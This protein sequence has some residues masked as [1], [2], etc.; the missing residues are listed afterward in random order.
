MPRPSTSLS[1]FVG[2]VLAILPPLLLLV[3]G[4]LLADSVLDGV[5]PN[6]IAIVIIAGSIG[7]AA[8]LAVIYGRS[9][10]EDVRAFLSV[11]ERGGQGS[12]LELGAAY[13]QL[14]TLLDERNQQVST[15]T[16]Q[17]RGIA[18]DDEPRAVVTALVSA[19]RRVMRDPTWRCAVLASDDP[20]LLPPGIYHGR[21]DD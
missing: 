12:E 20:E 7:W 5:E 8:I 2:L 3:A 15:L 14:A 19:V 18:I 6:L 9:L 4:I 11:A 21:E 16:E 1:V 10:S 13:R 17:A